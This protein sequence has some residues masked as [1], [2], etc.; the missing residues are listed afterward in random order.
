MSIVTA[1]AFGLSSEITGLDAGQSIRHFGI[2]DEIAPAHLDAVDAELLRRQLDETLAEK[3]SLIPARRAI[4]AGR[5]LIGDQRPRTEADVWNAVRPAEQLHDI[6]RCDQPVGAD[7]GTEIDKHI[8]AQPQDRP[9]ALA[10]DLD[11]AV[12]L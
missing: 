3:A 4:G 10:G 2:G 8:A 1:V 7:M 11:L 12:H 9:V 6:A 5:G